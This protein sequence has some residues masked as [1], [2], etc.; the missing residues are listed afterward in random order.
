ML[1]LHLPENAI[2]EL[3]RDSTAT[4]LQP[5]AWTEETPSRQCRFG[6]PLG[7]ALVVEP[8][9]RGQPHHHGFGIRLGEFPGA[10]LCLELCRRVI[11]GCQ[12]F[13][14]MLVCLRRRGWFR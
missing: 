2:Y 1:A 13:Q 9:F 5:E 4:H 7:E 6:K 14:G 8:S 11:T 10:K 12:E 3:G